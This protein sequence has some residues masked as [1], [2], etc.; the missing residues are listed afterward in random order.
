MFSSGSCWSCSVVWC[1]CVRACACVRV[2][3]FWPMWK[4]RLHSEIFFLYTFVHPTVKISV[5][6][7]CVLLN[8]CVCVF[9]MHEYQVVCVAALPQWCNDNNFCVFYFF[10]PHFSRAERLVKMSSAAPPSPPP[11]PPPRPHFKK[12]SPS[13]RRCSSTQLWG[14]AAPLLLCDKLESAQ[15]E[16]KFSP[17]S[18]VDYCGLTFSMLLMSFFLNALA[19]NMY[20]NIFY[21]LTWR[22]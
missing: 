11:P 4:R 12:V 8:A 9:Q 7:H 18:F 10:F 17:F 20:I 16:T 15:C 1:V 2:C 3:G 13:R 5:W 19:S 6:A 21:V 22:K 14:S